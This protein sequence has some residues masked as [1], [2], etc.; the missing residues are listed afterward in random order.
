MFVLGIDPGLSRCGYGVVESSG[1]N[2]RAVAAG[3]IRTPPEMDL[4][5]RL[6]E[7]QK[8]IH[9]LIADYQP[10]EVAVER[11]LFQVNVSSAMATGQAAGVTMAAAASTGLPVALY[12]P[13][14]VKLAVAGWGGADKQQMERMVQSQLSITKP[15]RPVDAA[16]AVAVAICHLAMRPSAALTAAKKQ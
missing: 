16:D 1:K 8:E 3:V 15:L 14:E 9:A 12:S 13:N 7:L 5:L 10:E 4:A 6:A 11:V 2:L